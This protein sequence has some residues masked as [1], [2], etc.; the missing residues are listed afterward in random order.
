MSTSVLEPPAQPEAG[1]QPLPS[2]RRRRHLVR[3]MAGAVL[4]GLVAVS[5][6]A[7][8]RPASQ[9]T[10]IQSPLVGH[11]APL[12]VGT[13]LSG[14][15]VSLASLRGRYVYVNFFA[16]WCPPCQEEEPNLI[17][18]AATQSRVPGGAALVSVVFNDSEA[19]ARQFVSQWGQPW[20]T[21]PDQGGTIANAFGVGAPPATF[22]VG[23][24]GTVL[25]VWDGPATVAQLQAMVRG[26]R[27][28]R[29]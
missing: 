20:P 5:I 29:G 3:W 25:G 16:S 9:A 19:A 14:Q 18:F 10:E 24:R 13:A 21:V 6:V 17:A 28:G 11:R 12:I 1:H 27:A 15:R 7:A 8:T 26:A 2:R 23:P 22:L 4:V